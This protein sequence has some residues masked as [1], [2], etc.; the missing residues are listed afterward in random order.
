MEITQCEHIL[1]DAI[2][3]K[4]V[5]GAR[6]RIK[7]LSRLSFWYT[8]VNDT[9]SM[10]NHVYQNILAVINNVLTKLGEGR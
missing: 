6:N 8:S 1:D 5:P 4:P 7:V 10:P 2:S 3:R 9:K